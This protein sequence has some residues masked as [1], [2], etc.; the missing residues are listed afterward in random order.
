MMH[1]KTKL[2]PAQKAFDSWNI[3]IRHEC[4]QPY[5]P[6]RS[7]RAADIDALAGQLRHAFGRKT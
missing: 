1:P 6:P 5:A 3:E 7:P 4:L 2:V